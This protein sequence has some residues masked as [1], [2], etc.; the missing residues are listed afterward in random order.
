MKTENRTLYF[1]SQTCHGHEYVWIFDDKGLKDC[2]KYEDIKNL[3]VDDSTCEDIL[4]PIGGSN[5]SSTCFI[6][7]RDKEDAKNMLLAAP[8][9]PDSDDPYLVDIAEYIRTIA[10]DCGS[11]TQEFIDEFN[12]KDEVI[13]QYDSR[14]KELVDLGIKPEEFY[15]E[16]R[17]EH[18][19]EVIK[20]IEMK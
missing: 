4:W 2:P 17:D 12:I 3:P 13:N 19:S 5:S 14:F 9:G 16:R 1:V 10:T 11:C 15:E 7:L 8:N 20:E 6:K 18:Y